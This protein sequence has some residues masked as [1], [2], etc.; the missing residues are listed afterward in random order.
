MNTN[1][2]QA[3]QLAGEIQHGYGDSAYPSM[4]LCPPYPFIKP[5]LDVL[6]N[7]NIFIGAQNCAENEQGAFTGEVSASML[8]SCCVSAVILGHSERR[9]MFGESDSI[10]NQKV[11]TALKNGLKVIFCCGETLEERELNQVEEIVRRQIEIGLDVTPEKPAD[12]IIVA[13]EPVWAIG[14][15]RTATPEQAQEVHAFI[16]SLLKQKF[17]QDGAEISILYGGS[18]NPSNARSLFSQPD[19]DGGLIGGASLNAADFLS[20]ARSF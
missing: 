12:Y 11:K 3:V 13:Y 19:I 1:Y 7:S 9:I 6:G 2:A 4:I 5:V 16:R 14:T 10:I 8:A 20:I 18:C 15:G 17:G